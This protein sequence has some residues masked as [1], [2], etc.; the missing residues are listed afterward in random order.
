M[1]GSDRGNRRRLNW[2]GNYERASS[3][4]DEYLSNEGEENEAEYDEEE[5]KEES[6]SQKKKQKKQLDPVEFMALPYFAALSSC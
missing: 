1:V 2:L 4:S 6:K 5:V 3:S